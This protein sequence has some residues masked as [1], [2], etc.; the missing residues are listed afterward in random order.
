MFDK[1]ELFK[2]RWALEDRLE[3]FQKMEN[4]VAENFNDVVEKQIRMDMWHKRAI[5]TNSLL[6]KVVNLIE[7]N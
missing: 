6:D 1:D 4:N 2:I 3:Y 7:M 5:E